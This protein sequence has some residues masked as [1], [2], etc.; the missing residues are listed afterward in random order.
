MGQTKKTTL[1]KHKQ[2]KENNK[3]K[4]GTKHTQTETD[5]AKSNNSDQQTQ[6]NTNLLNPKYLLHRPH[7]QQNQRNSGIWYQYSVRRKIILQH[8][9][10]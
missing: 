6:T 8:Q 9:C 4:K 1:H 10:G 5:A 3:K 7:M 2:A